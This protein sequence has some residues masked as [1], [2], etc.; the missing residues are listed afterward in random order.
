MRTTK[1]MTLT[2]QILIGMFLGLL[3]GTLINYTGLAENAFVEKTLIN[4]VLHVIGS[5][6]IASLKMMV[7]PLV[8]VSLTVGVTNM[9]NI[10][11]LGRIGIK[12]LSLYLL[13]TAIAIS[14]ALS[15]GILISPGEGFQL[16][17]PT[18]YEAPQAPS[19]I[20]TLIK[21]VPE[22]PVKAMADAEMLQVIIFALLFGIAITLAGERGRHVLNF[23]SDLDGVI[24]KMVIIIMKLAPYGV[25][26][27]IAK[28]FAAEGI[29]IILPLKDYFLTVIL[30]LLCH[31]AGTYSA[32]LLLL[33]KLDPRVFFKKM[34]SAM[35]FAFSTSSS[36]ATLPVTLDTVEN[37]LGVH[38]SV[39]SFTVPL[40]AT[41]NMDGTAIMQGVAAVFIANVYGIDLGLGQ[42][43]MII[44][45]ATLASI[46]TAGVPGVGLI[47][48]ALVLEQAGLPLE[49][50]GLIM[51]VDRLL[52]MMRTAVNI[53]GDAMVTC[54]V[55]QN[56]KAFDPNRFYD[57]EAGIIQS[58]NN[59]PTQ[60]GKD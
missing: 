59:D 7:V 39:A 53:T 54:L 22:N 16:T 19:L 13:T 30:A 28:T 47:M 20:E 1:K 8:F 32:F 11:A 5:L 51:G 57:P 36:N 9:G 27:L 43:L 40:G 55:A 2:A 10:A 17:E 60:A 3:C 34:R 46:G 58:G 29:K 42:Y 56:E 45:T 6:F 48:L 4:G 44:V 25:F 14:I 31:T 52:D 12:T 49:G 26:C 50:I 37:R 38:N 15:L 35:T 41:I 33:G 21:L 23:F 24:M 18:H